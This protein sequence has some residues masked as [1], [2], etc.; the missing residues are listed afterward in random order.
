MYY[1]IYYCLFCHEFF[2][3]FFFFVAAPVAYGSSWGQGLNLSC[4]CRTIAW[5]QRC[6]IR[7]ISVTY[8]IACGNARSLTHRVNPHPHGHRVGF[9]TH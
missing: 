3:F 7:A 5:P 6:Q 1:E 2:F 8:A 4:S 9:L